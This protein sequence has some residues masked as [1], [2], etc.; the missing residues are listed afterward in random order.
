MDEID[1]FTY[2]IKMEDEMFEGIY[3]YGWIFFNYS[4]LG[5]C[6][7]V[8]YA[9][10]ETGKF[11]NRGFLKG[12]L[13]P[14]YGIGA[15][16]VIFLFWPLRANLLLLF[17]GSVLLTSLLEFFTGYIL[18]KIFHQKWWNYSNKPFNL[19]GYICL[20]FSVLWGIVCIL[21]INIFHPIL[22]FPLQY[23]PVRI[24]WMLLGILF[25]LFSVDLIVTIMILAKI[26][27]EIR[28]A[29]IIEGSLKNVSE[30]IGINLYEGTIKT[31]AGIEQ[32]QEELEKIKAR[33]EKLKENNKFSR[34]RLFK[35][36]PEI[37]NFFGNKNNDDNETNR[38]DKLL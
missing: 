12:P 16:I 24:G 37:Q 33:Y 19:K 34:K 35:A 28:L 14:I 11:T 21:L 20:K 32:G 17:S 31:K 36:F 7:E 18:E 38:E 1:N 27:I 6:M 30:K 10:L 4:F 15:G 8:V 26:K 13:C 3:T 5:W 29:E 2:N 22:I 9:A 23:L 25:L